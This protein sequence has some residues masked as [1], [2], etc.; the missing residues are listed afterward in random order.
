MKKAKKLMSLLLAVIMVIGVLNV[1]P[2]TVGAVD[3]TSDGYKYTVSNSKATLTGYTGS[4]T[5]LNIP[6]TLGGYKVTTIGSGAFE[7]NKTISSVTIPNSVTSIGGSSF[8]GC[9]RL[10]TVSIGNSVDSMGNYAFSGCTSLNKVTIASGSL[11]IGS[12]AFYGC[13]SLNS[14]YIPDP[15][16]QIGKVKLNDDNL[17]DEYVFYNHPSSLT[18]Y[19]KSGSF[20]QQ[21]AEANGIKFSTVPELLIG[22]TNN[23]GTIS[24]LDATEIQKYLANLIKLSAE[25]KTVSDTNGDGNIDILDATHI[26]KYLAQ[27]IQL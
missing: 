7:N 11:V 20:A 12:Y 25:Q 6:S 14:I 18:I 17:K 10:T 15:F 23:D 4:S 9:T 21:F 24:I 2:F 27:L 13:T 3:Y 5:A 16:I 22:D 26:Q 8:S 19:G 1:A